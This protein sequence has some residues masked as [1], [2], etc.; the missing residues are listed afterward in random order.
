MELGVVRNTMGSY[1][2]LNNGYANQVETVISSLEDAPIEEVAMK[3]QSL[4]VRLQASY[5]TMSIV[6]QLSLVNFIR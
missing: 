4:Q 5:Q 3:I 1:N 6:S 2:D